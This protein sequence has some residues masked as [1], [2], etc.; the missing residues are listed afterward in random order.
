MPTRPPFK[1]GLLNTPLGLL[2]EMAF[3]QW[4]N[5]GS[6]PFNPDAGVTDYDMRGFWKAQ[7]QQNPLAL[8]AINPNDGM[9][10]YPDYWKTPLHQT[11]SRE[12]QW[13]KPTDPMWINDHQL[14]TQGGRIVHDETA[15]N[16]GG[17]FG[18][19]ELALRY[20]SNRR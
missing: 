4:V 7:Q 5:N 2:E 14:A 17:L 16:S 13:A 19:G 18:L 8:S 20:L 6:I 12:S 10:H 3:R 15:Q 9:M 1:R 11:F